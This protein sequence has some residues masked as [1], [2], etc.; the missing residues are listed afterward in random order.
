MAI[1]SLSRSGLITYDKYSSFLAGNEAY[2]PPPTSSY[3]LISSTILTSTTAS[4]TFDLTGLSVDYQHLQVR[5]M[6]RDNRAT[7]GGNWTF[8]RLNGDSGANY[9]THWLLGTNGAVSSS[10]T[11]N[12]TYMR[13]AGISTNDPAGSY[14]AAV[15]DL[16]DPFST[17]KY[18]T[19]KALNGYFNTATA[20]TSRIYLWSNN[21]RSTAAVTSISFA[22]DVA[23]YLAGS[24]FS[25]YGFKAA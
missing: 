22:T 13:I 20:D 18:K 11:V 5:M 4:V 23:S 12:N 7:T 24:R 19:M 2:I 25:L 8:M 21:W 14:S 10:S 1:K 9:S 15:V 17:T 6:I 16:L 3:D